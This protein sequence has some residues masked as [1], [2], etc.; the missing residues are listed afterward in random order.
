MAFLDDNA[1]ELLSGFLDGELTA[2][3]S[4]V[5]QRLLQESGEARE[6]LRR[7]QAIRVAFQSTPKLHLSGDF[8]ARVLEASERR[9]ISMG[10]QQ[11][12]WLGGVASPVGGE[13]HRPVRASSGMTTEDSRLEGGRNEGGRN[14]GRWAWGVLSTLAASG[15]FV[16]L[17]YWEARDGSG[18]KIQGFAGLSK[19]GVTLS[20]GVERRGEGSVASASE[21]RLKA[22]RELKVGET[23]ED[24]GNESQLAAD[25]GSTRQPSLGDGVPSGVGGTEGPGVVTKIDSA[26][27]KSSV[28]N[29]AANVAADQTANSPELKTGIAESD[30]ASLMGASQAEQL[31]QLEALANGTGSLMM[32]VDFSVTK[33]VWDS[34]FVPTLLGRYDVAFDGPAVVD[35]QM[36]EQLKNS[37]MVGPLDGQSDP[38]TDVALV[39]VK[40]RATRI[41]KM[42][43]EIA[44]NPRD[45]PEFSF[46]LSMDLALQHGLSTI[47]EFQEAPQAADTA[48]VLDR[49]SNR[50]DRSLA[51][52]APPERPRKVVGLEQRQRWTNPP[53]VDE[54]MDPVS[55]TLL[56]IRPASE[57]R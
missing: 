26:V 23:R 52:F 25:M 27:A 16:C 55:Y 24:V 34:N 2:S 12:I 17:S 54:K 41:E 18:A 29:S 13:L 10:H 38:S 48:R 36:L 28:S 44:V 53:V 31:K 4:V 47:R 15:L 3:E 40:A 8:A 56:I 1:K 50:V 22:D 19:P 42:I 21:E 51:R 5:A 9:A 32:V 7:L 35:D 46:D 20:E 6:E 37:R 43:E 11:P 33:E 57:K 14:R 49:R 39:F 45:F 30:I